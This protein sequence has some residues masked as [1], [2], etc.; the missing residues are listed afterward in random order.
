MLIVLAIYLFSN[1]KDQVEDPKSVG[2]HLELF[3]TDKAFDI[4]AWLIVIL[5]AVLYI[6]LW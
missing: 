3:R 1:A 4:G 2:V 6:A 5:L